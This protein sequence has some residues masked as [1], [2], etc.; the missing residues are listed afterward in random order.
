MYYVRIDSL[1]DEQIQFCGF[2]CVF[3]D[4]SYK[5]YSDYRGDEYIVPN[6]PPRYLKVDDLNDANCLRSAY[7]IQV[8]PDK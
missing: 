6:N 1:T 3:E 8:E 5:L 2:T 7:V 4:N